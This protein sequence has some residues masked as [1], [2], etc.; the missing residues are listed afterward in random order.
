MADE[1][2]PRESEDLMGLARYLDEEQE[3]ARLVEGLRRSNPA[4]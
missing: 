4:S 2:P 3:W 1:M